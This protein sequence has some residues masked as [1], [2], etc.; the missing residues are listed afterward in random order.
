MITNSA[1][2]LCTFVPE[3][4]LR[5]VSGVTGTLTERAGGTKADGECRTPDADPNPLGVAWSQE[6]GK[7]TEEDLDYV[8]DD[9]QKVFRR[10]GGTTLPTDLGE[11]MAVQLPY[12]L[13]T[14]QPYEV[15]AKFSCGAKKRMLSLSFAQ[16]V[17]ERDAITDMIEL[18]R[19]AQ[20]R[21]GELYNCTPGK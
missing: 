11:G 3:R 6:H 19:I 14:G 20:K 8:L 5:L 1:P 17:K 12:G 21:Y 18:M 15:V 16:F 13:F 2:Y 7:R 10:H 4:A 9:K